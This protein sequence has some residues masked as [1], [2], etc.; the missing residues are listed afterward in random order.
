MVWKSNSTFGTVQG[1]LR[2]RK[3]FARRGVGVLARIPASEVRAGNDAA[4]GRLAHMQSL[5]MDQPVE[6]L[7]YGREWTIRPG[8]VSIGSLIPAVAAIS[9]APTPA[10]ITTSS[11]AISPCRCIDTGNPAIGLDKCGYRTRRESSPVPFGIGAAPGRQNRLG[12]PS[13]A[14]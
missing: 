3:Q 7:P 8:G 11:A 6:Q 10:A 13:S 14:T 5:G 12:P 9:G 2:Y 4:F 1:C